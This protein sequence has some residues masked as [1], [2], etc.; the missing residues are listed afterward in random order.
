MSGWIKSELKVL[1]VL[2]CVSALLMRLSSWARL[3]RRS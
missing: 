1:K 2:T 3:V